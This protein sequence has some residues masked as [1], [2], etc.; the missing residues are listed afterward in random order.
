LAAALELTGGQRDRYTGADK[1]DRP[2]L[3]MRFAEASTEL[4]G[5][6]LLLTD[7]LDLLERIAGGADSVDNRALARYRAAY[8]VE[9]CRRAVDRVMQA[10]GA[11]SAFDASPIQQAFR[12]ITMAAKH[13]LANLD[14]SAQTYGR[15]LLGLDPGDVPL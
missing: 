15:T 9:L 2:G 1:A 5:A 11:R 14:G 12:D 10:T 13:E 8:A 3:Q 4:R 7:V 6:E